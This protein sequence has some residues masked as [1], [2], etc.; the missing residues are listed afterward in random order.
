MDLLESSLKETFVITGIKS[1][2]P[3]FVGRNNVE[4]AFDNYNGAVKKWREQD[5][6]EDKGKTP[7]T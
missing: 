5:C 1:L 4:Q 6:L 2:S 3:S 7:M